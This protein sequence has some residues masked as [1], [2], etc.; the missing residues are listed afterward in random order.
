MPE[1]GTKVLS[2]AVYLFCALAARQ[3][4]IK[5]LLNHLVVDV[6]DI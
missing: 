5:K 1:C 6:M 3:V 2:N 4:I